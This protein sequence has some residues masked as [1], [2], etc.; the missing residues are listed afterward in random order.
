[1]MNH[2]N[3]NVEMIFLQLSCTVK[4]ALHLQH[5]TFYLVFKRIEKMLLFI[6]ENST[7]AFISLSLTE[8][9]PSQK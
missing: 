8:F 6:P 5:A 4:R 9:Q 1:M 3:S 2:L 7:L